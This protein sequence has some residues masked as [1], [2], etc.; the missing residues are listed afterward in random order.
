MDRVSV[1]GL[2]VAREL[3]DFVEREALPGTGVAP[4]AFWT[5]LAAMLADLSPRVH[6]LL[7][8]RDALQ[9]KIDAWHDARRGK[10][11]DAAA[12]EAFL[13]E[14]GYLLPEPPT[15]SI[16]TENVDPRNR[17]HRGPAARRAGLKRPLCPEC[18][19]RPLGQ[20]LRRALR[21]GRHSRDR[22][23]RARQGV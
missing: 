14:I 20:P 22:R 3:H 16:D 19:Q 11:H 13:R 7:A 8:H 18:R 1:A 15:G 23:D 5:G 2:G 4:D 21:H 10:P 6:V 9:V 12:Y 17:Q